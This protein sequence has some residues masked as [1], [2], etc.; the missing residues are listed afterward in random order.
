[1]SLSAADQYLL[2]LMN[3]TRLDP[4]AEAARYGIGLN[5]DLDAG[6]IDVGSKQVLAPN[7][8]L[9]VAATRHSKWM[10]D[11]DTFSH[12]GQNGSLPW[13]R[14]STAGYAWNGIGENVAWVGSTRTLSLGASI[15][16][17]H[18][19]LFLSA[20][21]REN[22]MNEGYREVGVAAETGQFTSKTPIMPPW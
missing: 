7:A 1:M 15:D 4:G 20:G 13:D 2:E 12:T 6:T 10:L 19:N 5:K 8:L 17:L 14:A 22:L 3:R 18:R 16:S 11:E 9:D 21:H